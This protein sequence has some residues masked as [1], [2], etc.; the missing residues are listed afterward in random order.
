MKVKVLF[1]DEDSDLARDGRWYVVSSYKPPY[2]PRIGVWKN[3]H[4]YAHKLV[5][6]RKIGREL[7]SGEL[8]DHINGNVLDCRR[9]NLRVV[10]HKGS[11]QNRPSK[12]GR[13]RGTTFNKSAGKWQAYVKTDGRQIHLGVFSSRQEAARVASLKRTELRFLSGN[14]LP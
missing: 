1:S 4:I 7:R 14:G 2:Y 8:A 12:N 10:D 9:E 13:F 6:S 11:V 5:L 3:K